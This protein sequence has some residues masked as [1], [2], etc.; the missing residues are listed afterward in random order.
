L[1]R[2]ELISLESIGTTIEEITHLYLNEGKSLKA[3]SRKFGISPNTI[4]NRLVGNNVPIRT[5]I[6]KYDF[7][8]N[9]FDEINTEEKAYWLGFIWCDGSVI[10]SASNSLSVKVSLSEVD[11]GHLVKLKEVLDADHPIHYYEIAQGYG[12]AFR[13]ARLNI[14]NTH[15]GK[16]LREVYGMIPYRTDPYMAIERVPDNLMRHFIRGVYDADGSIS[17]Y[18]AQEKD[19]RNPTMKMSL[20]LYTTEVLIDFIQ[21]YFVT[22][23]LRETKTK[24]IK[25]HKGRDGHATGLNISGTNQVVG[26]LEYLYGDSSVH[27]ERKYNK[28]LELKEAK[29]KFNENYK[30]KNQYSYLY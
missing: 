27:L 2:K 25:R 11:D 7:N 29:R 24:T 19:C 21:G 28:F 15:F 4:K 6:A 30:G 9:F 13:E 12:S 1:A 16:T 3:L 10:S 14:G 17:L 23:R 18:Y 20:Q 5:Q 26:I 22:E 8:Q